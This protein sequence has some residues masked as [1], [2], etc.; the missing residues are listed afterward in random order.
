MVHFLPHLIALGPSQP[1]SIVLVSSGLAIVPIPRCAN[2][3]A[4]KAAVHSLA[5]TLRSQLSGPASPH[6]N[7]IRVIE[8]VPPAVQT[9]LH[10]QQPDV[11]AAGQS[12]IGVPLDMWADETWTAMRASDGDGGDGRAIAGGEKGGEK[13]EWE[14]ELMVSMARERFGKIEEEKRKG[15]KFFE[16]LVRKEQY[17]KASKA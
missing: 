14:D 4:S 10:A 11:V 16:D 8:I 7:H 13:D 17:W 12:K 3:C 5:W 9:E 15:F 6:T 1:A 2:Y